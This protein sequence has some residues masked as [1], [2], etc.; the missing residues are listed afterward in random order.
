MAKTD[1]KAVQRKV[2]KAP[3]FKPSNLKSFSDKA[4]LGPNYL[5]RFNG[6]LDEIW[7]RVDVDGNKMLDKAETKNFIEE[8]QKIVNPEMSGSYE[9]AKFDQLFKLYDDDK[10]GYLE[11]AEMTVFIQKSFRKEG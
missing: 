10:N 4:L 1:V 9:P 7:D 11:K 6:N 2:Q 8:L 5:K 3:K